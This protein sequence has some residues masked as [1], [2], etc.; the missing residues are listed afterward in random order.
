MTPSPKEC[1]ALGL[2]CD[3]CI[4][5]QAANLRKLT[6]VPIEPRRAASIFRILYPSR[7]CSRMRFAFARAVGVQA[8]LKAKKAGAA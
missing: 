5:A 3:D 4:N 2:K 1:G 6:G 8:P 7:H